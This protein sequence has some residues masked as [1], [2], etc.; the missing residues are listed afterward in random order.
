MIRK[1]LKYVFDPNYRFIIDANRGKYNNL[2]DEEFLKRKFK[3]I[4]GRELDLKAPQTFN[5]KLQWLKLYNRRPE[6][7]MLVDKYLVRNYIR[8]RLGEQ[9]LIPLVGAWDSPDEIDFD[10]LPDK[11]VLKC[12]HNSGV[13]MYIC[14]DK[15]KMDVEKVKRELARGLAQDYYLT[16]REWPYKDVPRKIICE[17][18]MSDSEG[19]T[20]FTD[21]K[22]FCFGGKVDCVMVCLERSSGDT[23]FYFFD[24]N[25]ELKRL[26]IRGKNAP[27]GFTIPKP[28]CMDEMFKIAAELSRGMPF[29]R[30]DLYQSNGQIYF[31]E[32]TY[33]PDSGFDPNLLAETDMYFGSLI[34]I[35]Q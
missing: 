32:M 9:Y 8:E 33:F 24:Q 27:E 6:Y 19:A 11:F 15:S 22:F 26:N 14:R 30:V 1:A 35:K 13:G 29:V 10:A 23:K 17:K 18:F 34:N 16:G 21:Y 25:W 31:G 28:E 3:V 20:D 4:F 12:N 5:E 2:P 7:T